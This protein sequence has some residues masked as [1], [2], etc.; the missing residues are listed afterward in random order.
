MESV[1]SFGVELNGGI[2]GDSMEMFAKLTS[3][4]S[5]IQYKV[6]G[7]RLFETCLES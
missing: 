4:A 5:Q 1:G 6:F 7:Y 3:A 2:P